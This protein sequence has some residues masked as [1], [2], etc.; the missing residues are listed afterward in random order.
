MYVLRRQVAS[1]TAL[2]FSCL[3]CNQVWREDA[4]L[5]IFDRFS[6]EAVREINA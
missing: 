6:A 2:D 3:G 4:S 1:G 5:V